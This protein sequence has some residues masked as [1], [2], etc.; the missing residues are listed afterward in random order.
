MIKKNYFGYFFLTFFGILSIL[1]AG[2]SNE[3]GGDSISRFEFDFDL[4]DH[5]SIEE[6]AELFKTDRAYI[7]TNY[8]EW[9]K[10]FIHLHDGEIGDSLVLGCWGNWL[11]YIQNPSAS[12]KIWFPQTN[13]EDGIYQ[14]SRTD[15]L[16]DF[17]IRIEKNMQW[18][19]YVSSWGTY[20]GSNTILNSEVVASARN[21]SNN[22]VVVEYAE[23][24]LENINT[25]NSEIRYVI[26][27][28]N[29]HLIKGSFIG[30]LEDFKLR[31]PEIDCD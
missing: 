3:N 12:V 21:T 2:C 22:S 15:A 5:F 11:G 23:I 29:G 31:T 7:D 26:E 4:N 16:N 19:E 14:Y 24:K 1:S 17:S 8:E 10:N 18:G 30:L 13:L 9:A 20:E 28:S 6:T 25:S 27:T